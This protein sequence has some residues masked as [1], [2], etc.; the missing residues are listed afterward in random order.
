M[1]AT[2]TVRRAPEPLRLGPFVLESI[3]GFGGMGAV[4]R[5][6]HEGPG[7]H[8]VAVKV[9]DSELAQKEQFQT[10]F[11]R[12]VMAHA[13]LDHPNVVSVYDHGIVPR[14]V[15]REALGIVPGPTW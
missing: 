11:A 1:E 2:G 8:L 5:G 10:R 3:I 4:W 12:E 14:H 15:S 6:M 13:E 7:E 9:L